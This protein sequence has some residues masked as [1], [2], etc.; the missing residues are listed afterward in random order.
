L[1]AQTGDLRGT[2]TDDDTGEPIM[3][4]TVFVKETS[5]GSDTDLDGN[6]DLKLAPGIYT[7]EFSYVGYATLTVEQVE[8]VADQVTQLPALLKVEGQELDE[9]VVTAKAIQ[10]TEVALET[11]TQGLYSMESTYLV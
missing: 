1:S 7:V 10:N 2:L 9:I 8:I 6:F 11:D 3:F 4:G 5:T